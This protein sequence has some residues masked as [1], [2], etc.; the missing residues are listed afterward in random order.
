MKNNTQPITNEYTLTENRNITYFP[1]DPFIEK[2]YNLLERKIDDP[3]LNISSLAK[4]LN[5][6]RAQLHRKVKLSLGIPAS[7]VVRN[8]RLYKSLTYLK[9]GYNSSEAAFMVG[10][11]SPSY[12]SKCFKKL[13]GKSPIQYL[14][15]NINTI[16]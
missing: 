6:S 12:F 11:D 9:N 14:K 2:I 1:I 13:F 7:E 16:H 4:S 10:F 15:S 5:V 3:Y 8:Y